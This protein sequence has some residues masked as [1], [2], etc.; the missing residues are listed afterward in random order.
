MYI[1]I[2]RV[3]LYIV[4]TVGQ[5]YMQAFVNLLESI[6]YVYLAK[7]STLSKI[8]FCCACY[9]YCR[10]VLEVNTRSAHKI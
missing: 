10:Q 8:S 6:G 4:N 7:V 5:L 3:I 1:P 9:C 2:I